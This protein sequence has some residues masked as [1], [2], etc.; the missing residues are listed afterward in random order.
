MKELKQLPQQQLQ[1]PQL[2]LVRIEDLQRD[3]FGEPFVDFGVCNALCA[4]LNNSG[5]IKFSLVAE[6]MVLFKSIAICSYLTHDMK[7][8]DV[9]IKSLPDGC[10]VEVYP[11]DNSKDRRMTIKAKQTTEVLLK[12]T[13]SSTAMIVPFSESVAFTLLLRDPAARTLPPG[14]STGASCRQEHLRERPACTRMSSLT[15]SSRPCS[16]RPW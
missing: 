9:D 12:L 13:S 7:V 8:W 10:E 2:P 4:K 11:I 15:S 5:P 16:T 1:P 14:A 3:G 6:S